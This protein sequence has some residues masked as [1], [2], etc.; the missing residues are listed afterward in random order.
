MKRILVLIFA[1]AMVLLC[2][3]SAMMEKEYLSITEYE[4]GTAQQDSGEIGVISSYSALMNTLEKMVQQ[5][6]STVQLQ[7]NNY[8]GNISDDLAE[9]GWQL[10]QNSALGAY[11]VDYI[12]YDISRIV[13][14]YQATVY[15]N[16]A[17]TAQDMAD[18][19]TIG[20]N[21]ISNTVVDAVSAGEEKLV[22]Q[23]YTTMSDANDMAQRIENALIEAPQKVAVIPVIDVTVYPDRDSHDIFEVDFDYG[24]AQVPQMQV[25]LRS[26][27]E[28]AAERISR[29]EQYSIAVL[30]AGLVGDL[31]T[32]EP[33]DL[34]GTAYDALVLGAGGSRAV[35]MAYSAICAEKGLNVRVVSG[36]KNNEQHYWSLVKIGDSWYH[37][38]I[39]EAMNLSAEDV[40]LRTDS[41]MVRSFRWDELA[42]PSCDGV[43]FI[44][45]AENSAAQSEIKKVEEN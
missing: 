30:A 38:D 3:C 39:S 20:A 32:Y 24:E 15:I 19:R 18:I 45:Q 31:C 36:L 26:A 44:K 43:S 42:Y 14:Y 1:A 21:R 27:I 29:D 16:Y 23:V 2:G 35:S 5:H 9:A 33:G 37:A 6:Q 8:A 13:T 22:M 11:M 34:D 28:S 12:S 17:R 4:T 10:K 41:E 40:F 25:Q 7:F